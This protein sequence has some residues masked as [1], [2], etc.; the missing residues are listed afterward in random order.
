MRMNLWIA[1]LLLAMVPGGPKHPEPAYACTIGALTRAERTRHAETSRR[2]LSAIRERTEL[3][4]GYGFRLP[5]ESLLTAAQWIS[6]ERRCC[7]F[8][9]FEVEQTKDEG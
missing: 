8:F 2:L 5:P 3:V 4:H 9:A 7:P 6:L 1:P